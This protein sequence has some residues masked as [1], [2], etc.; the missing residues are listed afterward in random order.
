[1]SHFKGFYKKTYLE[2]LHILQE[3]PNL[4]EKTQHTLQ[5]KCSLSYETANTIIEN[6]F[7]VYGIPMGI[8]PNILIDG[9]IFHAPLATEEPS[10]IAAA[11]FGAQLITRSGGFT[12]ISHQRIMIGQI[13][14]Y[15]VNNIDNTIH[16]LMLHKDDLIKDANLAYPSIV[17][18]G[19]GAK[20]LRVECK[21]SLDNTAFLIVYLLVDTQEAMGANILNTMLEAIT[22]KIEKLSHAP[23]L[24]SILSNYATE[25][26]ISV[27]CQIPCALLA[28]GE[29]TSGNT[30]RDHII[31]AYQLATA[32]VYR[33]TTHNKGIMNGISAVVLATGNDT[34]AIEAGAH[35]YASHTGTY[36]PLTTWS[37][38]ENGDLKGSITLPLP[39]GF[40][41]GSIS[42][43]PSAQMAQ[44][45]SQTT[46]AKELS[47]LIASIGLAQNFSALRALVTD[48]I[49]KGHM[50]LQLKSLALTVGAELH[51][52]EPLIQ[53]LK[54]EKNINQEIAKNYLEKLRQN[55]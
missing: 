21:Y 54:Q 26:L 10:V 41:G 35:A 40:V 5:E 38:T 44:N 8:V 18:R 46:S 43:H 13:A 19:G 15:H 3:L 23:A 9:N 22:P 7:H 33:A 45:L 50:A 28:K 25:S 36:F 20:D 2:R 49:Q 53:Q 52:I 17:K 4:S 39:I 55:I 1:M 37:K 42:I 14:L 29:H 30:V 11:N 34:R 27:S 32:D 48:G 12:T 16:K 6:F 47:S 24:M 51:E 31:L